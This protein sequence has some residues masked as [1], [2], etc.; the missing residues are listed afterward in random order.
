METAMNIKMISSWKNA[1]Q[2]LREEFNITEK[3]SNDL[4]RALGYVP[5]K[6]QHGLIFPSH[7]DEHRNCNQPMERENFISCNNLDYFDVIEILKTSRNRTIKAKIA[8]DILKEKLNISTNESCRLLNERACLIDQE[9]MEKRYITGRSRHLIMGNVKCLENVIDHYCSINE[10]FTIMRE[11]GYNDQQ[12]FLDFDAMESPCGENKN[13]QNRENNNQPSFEGAACSE[14]KTYNPRYK[15]FAEFIKHLA[16]HAGETFN[17]AQ[18]PFTSAQAVAEYNKIVSGH[19][20]LK[21]IKEGNA[22]NQAM[23]RIKPTLKNILNS[24]EVCFSKNTQTLFLFDDI[25][26]KYPFKIK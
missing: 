20:H 2:V 9:W 13:N 16:D 8:T 12:F 21:I 3:D 15:K 26:K 17:R 19:D 7:E 1:L 10:L 24:E 23:R 14:N 22:L 5:E 25:L 6:G 11:N 18:L 4:L